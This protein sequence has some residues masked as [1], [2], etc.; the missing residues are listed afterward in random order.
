MSFLAVFVAFE[1]IINESSGEELKMAAEDIERLGLSEC[2]IVSPHWVLVTYFSGNVNS[3]SNMDK[4]IRE[5]D[6]VL[7]F[8]NYYSI[9][10]NLEEDILI[11]ENEY[12]VFLRNKDMPESCN[13]SYVFDETYVSNHCEIISDKFIAL[14]LKKELLSLCKKV[15]FF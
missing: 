5:G 13:E 6:V 9:N 1:M 7:I 14:G 2:S 10:Y 3:F 8:K 4:S 15:N 11:Y 12:Y